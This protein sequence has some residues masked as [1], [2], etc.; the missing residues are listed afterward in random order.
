MSNK[1][2]KYKYSINDYNLFTIEV[3]DGDNAINLVDEIDL[4]DFVNEEDYVYM[5]G[6]FNNENKLVLL[7]DDTYRIKE[8][9]IC[10]EEDS[11][12]FDILRVYNRL[13]YVNGDNYS[14]MFPLIRDLLYV[15]LRNARD[16]KEIGLSFNKSEVVLRGDFIDIGRDDF[17]III[18]LTED[19]V[20]KVIMNDETT[21]NIFKSRMKVLDFIEKWIYDNLL[22]LMEEYKQD[23]GEWDNGECNYRIVKL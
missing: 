20:Y 23:R 6:H 9:Y 18:D 2:I 7:D 4:I 17:K 22:F 19:R 15:A 1:Y 12:V 10:Q 5:F 21:V 16:D 8:R 3:E 13:R 14:D 11:R